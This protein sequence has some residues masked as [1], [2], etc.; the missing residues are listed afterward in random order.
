VPYYPIIN[1]ASIEPQDSEGG[2]K[3]QLLYLR[4]EDEFILPVFTSLDRFWAFVDKY[5]AEDDS[6]QPSTFPVT[7]FRLAEMIGLMS[8][9]GEQHTLIFNPVVVSAKEWRSTVKPIPAAEYCRFMT[10]ISPD[11]EKLNR[12]AEAKF[13]HLP[14]SE[15]RKKSLEWVGTH[16]QE[17]VD[18]A[19]ARIE[20]WQD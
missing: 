5:Y 20:E 19:R 8:Q 6:V 2:A 15:A 4:S 14:D 11:L 17:V 12:E 10:E 3:A 7:P 16:I 1:L 18:N 9:G 13:C